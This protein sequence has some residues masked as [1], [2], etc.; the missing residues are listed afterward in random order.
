MIQMS[1]TVTILIKND[2]YF[3]FFSIFQIL[4]ELKNELAEFQPPKELAIEMVSS[5]ADCLFFTLWGML[6]GIRITAVVRWTA[7]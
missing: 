3:F 7:G 6:G 2:R 4:A 5:T 1:V